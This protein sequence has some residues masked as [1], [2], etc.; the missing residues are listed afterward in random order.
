M[1]LTNSHSMQQPDL[2]SCTTTMQSTWRYLKNSS[3]HQAGGLYREQWEY[4]VDRN[5]I[6]VK[7][8]FGRDR[9]M[10]LLLRF[11]QVVITGVFLV[12]W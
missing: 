2:T 4:C 6:F 8:A 3:Q 11:S 9:P 12:F 7:D 1:P 10:Q 5:F